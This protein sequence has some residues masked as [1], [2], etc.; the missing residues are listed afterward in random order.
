MYKISVDEKARKL[1]DIHVSYSRHNQTNLVIVCTRFC[2][3]FFQLQC[4]LLCL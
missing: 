1:E 4:D 3:L 2:P